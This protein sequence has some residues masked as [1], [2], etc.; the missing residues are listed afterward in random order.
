M[1][2]AF[3]VKGWNG[4]FK[5]EMKKKDTKWLSKSAQKIKSTAQY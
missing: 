1:M 4:V 2:D 5:A 3:S